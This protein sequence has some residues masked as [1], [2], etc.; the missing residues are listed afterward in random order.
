MQ[1]KLKIDTHLKLSASELIHH[2]LSGGQLC[3]IPDWK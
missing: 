1:E 3:H 2:K